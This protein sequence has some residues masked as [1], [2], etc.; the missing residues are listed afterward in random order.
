MNLI[1]S[2]NYATARTFAQAQEIAPGD[3]KWI[4]EGRVLR[5]YPRAD[6]YKIAH[7]EANPHR[8][9]IDAA[10]ERARHEHR[11]ARSPTT[12]AHTSRRPSD[13]LDDASSPLTVD[14]ATTWLTAACAAR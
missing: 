5:D 6:I 2:N 14:I 9:D 11:L 4:N 1:Y 10:M 7:W 8:A 13:A 12:V 3:W